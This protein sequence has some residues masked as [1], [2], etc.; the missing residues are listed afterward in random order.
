MRPEKGWPR[1]GAEDLQRNRSS[2]LET[3]RIAAASEA[4]FRGPSGRNHLAMVFEVFEVFEEELLPTDRL[5]TFPVQ[6][7]QVPGVFLWFH[8]GAGALKSRARR[9]PA[10]ARSHSDKL[11]QIESDIFV[12]ALSGGDAGYLVHG[13]LPG[14]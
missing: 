4:D 7:K 3:A 6:F 10:I 8:G 11:H 1:P 14:V 2:R 12:A 9:R 5:Q 13:I